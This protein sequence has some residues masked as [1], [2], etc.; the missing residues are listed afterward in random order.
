MGWVSS[1]CECQRCEVI[2][3]RVLTPIRGQRLVVAVA[4]TLAGQQLSLSKGH[5]LLHCS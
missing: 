5:V 2:C 3:P 1:S 4:N